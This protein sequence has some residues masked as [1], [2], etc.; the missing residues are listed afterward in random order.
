MAAW[1]AF[2]IVDGDSRR[3]TWALLGYLAAM[4]VVTRNIAVVYLALPA[5][6]V[7]RQLRTWRA[8]RWLAVGAA[9]PL[10]VQFVAWKILYGSWL[11]YSYGQDRFDPAQFDAV[12][13]L[14]S[15]WHGWFY[16]HPLLFAAVVAFVTWAVRRT[17]GQMWLTS[18]A[19][20][21]V[22]NTLWPVWW[23][24]SSF[25][26]RGFDAATLYAMIGGAALWH[27]TTMRPRLRMALAAVACVA[28]VWNLA[29]LALFLTQRISRE[30]AVTYG[31]MLRA[32]SA[33]FFPGA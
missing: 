30:E 9:G 12:R 31:D 20:I 19:S 10:A 13:T 32:V 8:A 14:F 4:L 2:R 28:I 6:I 3:R 21:F 11:V 25:G 16:W 26:H 17:E 33:W 29:L 27:A 18:L 1:V 24:G 15:P 22:L 7:A 5:W 23:F